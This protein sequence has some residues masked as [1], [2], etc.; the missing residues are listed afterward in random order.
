MLATEAITGDAEIAHMRN[1][2]AGAAAQ[3]SHEITAFAR[4]LVAVPSAYPPGDTHAIA[5]AIE[6]MFEG[7]DVSVER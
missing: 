7:F 3:S 5:D 6:A 1:A 2:L 4:A